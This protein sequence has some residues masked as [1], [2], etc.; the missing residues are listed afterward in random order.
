MGLGIAAHRGLKTLEHGGG[1]A[2]YRTHLLAYPTEGVGVVV[3]GNDAALWPG[4]LA[5]RVAEA[6]LGERMTPAPARP[7]P[8][9]IEEIKALAGVY[10]AQSGDV[11]SLAEQDG[12]LRLHG[13]P[14]SLWPLGPASF[15]LGGDRDVLR[16]EFE[17]AGDAFVLSQVGAPDRRFKRCE[18]PKDVDTDPL[19]GEF[20][21]RETGA[22]CT[23]S[24]TGADLAVS[25]AGG[26]EVALRPIAPDCLLADDFGATL[27]FSRS[28]SGA[29]QGFDLD[30]GRLRRIAYRR[31]RTAAFPSP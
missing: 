23:V 3:L 19:I 15:A 25:F 17:A 8:P 27:T 21:S 1:L 30:A 18:P 26:T 24:R 7:P 16:L 2:G 31:V 28:R 11:L 14:Q 20:E 29:V 9:P 12:K 5:R 22:G 10:R 6:W 13:I 4:Q